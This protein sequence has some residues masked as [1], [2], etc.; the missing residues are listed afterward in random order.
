MEERSTT[1]GLRASSSIKHSKR[2]ENQLSAIRNQ[3]VDLEKMEK[4][5]NTEYKHRIRK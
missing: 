1:L 5:Y 4:S 2:L 3:K